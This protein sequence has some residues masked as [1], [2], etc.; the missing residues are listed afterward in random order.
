MRTQ[1]PQLNWLGGFL[2]LTSCPERDAT[3]GVADDNATRLWNRTVARHVLFYVC[4]AL[5]A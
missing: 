5:D 2:V 4:Q 3:K 1:S